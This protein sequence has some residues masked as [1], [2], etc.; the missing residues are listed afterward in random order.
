M[1][2]KRERPVDFVRHG[3][4]SLPIRHSP[5]TAWIDDPESPHREGEAPAR[6]QKVYDSFYVDARVV[7]RGRIRATSIAE[8][9]RKGLPIAKELAKEGES[10]I[11]LPPEDR[12]IYVL[13]RKAL[14]P[15]KIAVDEGA[16][17]LA[18]MLKAL[19]GVSFDTVLATFNA[20]RADLKIGAK[21]AEI[22][23]LYLKEQEE[24]RGNSDYHIRDVKKWVGQF[25]DKFPGELIPISK[26]KIQDW[27]KGLGGKPPVTTTIWPVRVL[28]SSPTAA[29]IAASRAAVPS[30][31]NSS[32]LESARAK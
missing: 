26:D 8:A 6:V 28:S 31:S 18:E 23:E 10:A 27:L 13:A 19:D 7:G 12:R 16:R 3:A 4:V 20:G 17:R 2:L 1:V 25:C 11:Q 14:E 30:A 24:I 9:K 5:V 15:F 22:Y 21:T 32:A 29:A